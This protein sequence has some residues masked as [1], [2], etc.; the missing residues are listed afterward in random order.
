MTNK[1][2]KILFL[3]ID[4]VLNCKDTNTFYSIEHPETYGIDE[5]LWNNFQKFLNK[6]PDVKVVIH[7][8][9]IKHKDEP[10]YVWDMGHPE[11]GVKIKSKLLEVIRRLGDRYLDCVPYIKN[12][13]KWIR[14]ETWL[15]QNNMLSNSNCPCIVLDDDRSSYTNLFALERYN[16]VCV[17]FTKPETGLDDMT[18]MDLIEIGD[19]IYR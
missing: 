19:V 18:L 8:G 15:T 13:P 2:Q 12:E 16:N 6:F 11:L 9:W 14:I 5:H 10:N 1:K 4:G 17:K 3:D 7:S